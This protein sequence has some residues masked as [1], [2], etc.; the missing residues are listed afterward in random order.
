[1]GQAIDIRALE[2]AG[3]LLDQVVSLHEAGAKLGRGGPRGGDGKAVDVE[4]QAVAG[5]AEQARRGAREG[6]AVGDGGVAIAATPCPDAQVAD[7]L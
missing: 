2:G 7:A 3:D 5:E 6:G 1:M 4:G